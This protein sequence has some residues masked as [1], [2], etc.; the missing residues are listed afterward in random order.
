MMW[1]DENLTQGAGASP[2]TPSLAA[3]RT[4]RDLREGREP[5]LLG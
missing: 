1:G 3:A 4:P 5:Q 2:R